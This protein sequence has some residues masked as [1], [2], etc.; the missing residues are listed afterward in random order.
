MLAE[1]VFNRKVDY[2]LRPSF[3]P[4]P[5]PVWKWTSG[6]NSLENPVN[7]WKY[8]EAGMVHPH[9][10]KSVEYLIRRSIPGVALGMDVERD[11]ITSLWY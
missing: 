2:R 1:M 6:G 11:D 3:S 8:W 4:S 10:L 5:N 9:V 7:G